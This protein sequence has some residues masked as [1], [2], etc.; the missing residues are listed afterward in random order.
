MNLIALIAQLSSVSLC[1][2]RLLSGSIKNLR[3]TSVAEL[4]SFISLWIVAFGIFDECTPIW[5]APTPGLIELRSIF[6][7]SARRAA[8]TSSSASPNTSNLRLALLYV[9]LHLQESLSGEYRTHHEVF[10]SLQYMPQS[11]LYAVLFSQSQDYPFPRKSLLLGSAPQG[12]Q[13]C[14]LSS[15]SARRTGCPP[16]DGR[17]SPLESVVAVIPCV[18]GRACTQS[19]FPH[20]HHQS[21]PAL[22]LAMV[23]I[24]V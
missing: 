4:Y 8:A 3:R 6:V 12:S 13:S 9:S 1:L 17:G 11:R 7:E 23:A 22:A 15:S 21:H 2:Q 14:D 19:H 10:P 24:C 16:F 5:S 20:R 18:Y